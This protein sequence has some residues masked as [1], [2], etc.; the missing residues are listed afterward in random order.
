MREVILVNGNAD[1]PDR[2]E[3]TVVISCDG[4]P[5]WD[6]IKTALRMRPDKITI[7]LNKKGE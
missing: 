4:V 3:N 2:G 7:V 5:G 1:W 6:L